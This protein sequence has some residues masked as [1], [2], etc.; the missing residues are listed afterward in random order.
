VAAAY[1]ATVRSVVLVITAFNAEIAA[2]EEHVTGCLG[3]P[4]TLGST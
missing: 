4:G 3:R 2:M 1:A